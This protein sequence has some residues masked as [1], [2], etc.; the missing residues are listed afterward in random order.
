MG[1]GG[2]TAQVLLHKALVHGVLHVDL[3]QHRAVH[4][5]AVPVLI[6][7][8]PLDKAGH[9]AVLLVQEPQALLARVPQSIEVSCIQSAAG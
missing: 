6:V 5:R 2:H 9:A 8:E 7:R 3:C 1:R 4:A